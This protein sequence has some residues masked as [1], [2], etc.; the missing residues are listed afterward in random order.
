M[1]Q[2][3]TFSSVIQQQALSHKWPT[4]AARGESTR[5]R[6][7]SA[8]EV[9]LRRRDEGDV[10]GSS[11]SAHASVAPAPPE[12]FGCIG[13]IRVLAQV[14][15]ASVRLHG[16]RPRSSH[17]VIRFHDV[18]LLFDSLACSRQICIN[19]ACLPVPASF[20][21]APLPHKAAPATPIS[22]NHTKHIST[23]FPQLSL[24]LP[25]AAKIFWAFA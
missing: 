12:P 13:S 4:S 2:N 15:D 1:S 14:H 23:L 16:E 22:R 8:A 19:C 24:G 7:P 5:D 25:S 9:E 21:R 20:S 17:N 6:V 10:L 11:W 18:M 3:W